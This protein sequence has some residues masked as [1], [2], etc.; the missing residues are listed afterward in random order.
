[1]SGRRLRRKGKFEPA[2]SRAGP[3][4]QRRSAC[5]A[6]VAPAHLLDKAGR[7]RIAPHQKGG[8][9]VAVD[10]AGAVTRLIGAGAPLL[11]RDDYG[12]GRRTRG[13][14]RLIGPV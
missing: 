1:M 11:D 8:L 4:S 13:F 10:L 5:C 2:S 3:P 14:Y 7:G 12:P 6:H 9:I